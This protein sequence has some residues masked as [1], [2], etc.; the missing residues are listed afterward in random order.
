[1]ISNANPDYSFRSQRRA[2]I[3]L[4]PNQTGIEKI[5]VERISRDSWNLL[6]KFVSQAPDVPKQVVPDN[7]TS[8]NIRITKT[9]GSVE[10]NLRIKEIKVQEDG[11]DTLTI[12]LEARDS[13]NP[14]IASLESQSY[15]L[16][17]I[18]LTSV[19]RFFSRG[20]FTLGDFGTAEGELESLETADV[21]LPLMAPIDYLAK[22]YDS[23][24]KLILD[25][26]SLLVPNWRERNPSDVGITIVEIMAYVADYLSYFQ[27]SVANEAYLGTAAQRISV[28]R[29]ARLLGYQMHQGCNARAWVQVK[30]EKDPGDDSRVLPS[31]TPVFT[32]VSNLPT[33]INPGSPEYSQA[34]QQSPRFFETM[35]EIKLYEA[36]NEMPVYAWGVQEYSLMKGATNAALGGH[37]PNLKKGD[38][39]I[40]KEIK[41]QWTGQEDD[42]NVQ[43]RHAVRLIN[44]PRLT[45]DDLHNDAPITEVEWANEDALPSRMPVSSYEAGIHIQ[46]ITAALGNVVLA[47]QG[48][49]I[50]D[51]ELPVVSNITYN[52]RLSMRPLTF[53]V[54][55]D[56]RGLVSL[57]A[58]K[59][60]VQDP[61]EAM[62]AVLELVSE[63]PLESLFNDDEDEEVQN[64]WLAQTDLISSGRFARDFKVESD[65]DGNAYLFFGDGINGRRPL[66]GAGFQATYRI[67]NG[68]R[69]NVGRD[70]IR[71]IVTDMDCISSVENPLPAQGGIDAETMEEVRIRAP[72]EIRVQQRCVNALD[73][74][75]RAIEHP[76]VSNAIA[77]IRWTG[78]WHTVFIYVD[79]SSGRP[80]DDEFKIDLTDFMEDFRM[81][82]FDLEICPPKFVPLDIA[83][84]VYLS[85]GYLPGI[86]R[87]TLMEEFSNRNL[88]DGRRG[89]FHPDNFTFGDHVYI[90]RV[91]E[92]AAQVRGVARVEV[93]RFGRWTQTTT[94]VQ[95]NNFIEISP[96]EIA[97]VDNNASTPWNGVIEFVMRADQ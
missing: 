62:P 25:R 52:P 65:N 6:I 2:A 36:H 55:N 59:I 67:G 76:Q 32:S 46:D 72:Q 70:A 71:H 63:H 51:E 42:A 50:E 92:R 23:F 11:G 16:E 81:T 17:L 73:Y 45:T 82:G 12:L 19:D 15:T 97:K 64:K 69:G 95:V 87:R 83:L 22:D 47:D 37:Y 85:P 84:T 88:S 54:P 1:M 26:L 43:S 68:S 58:N 96:S 57:P 86:V 61:K 60:V 28:A 8:S 91:V 3:R 13:S 49:T 29:H 34:L 21:N 90:S 77:E 7:V 18:G 5:E 31:R 78:G 75:E 48:R 27:D 74:A 53:G 94:D 4:D 14:A 39:L 89:L 9:D 10:N 20:T 30:L 24:R 93:T 38:V 79:R 40:F 33:K 35:D 44:I 56:Q 66:V 80:I 41:G